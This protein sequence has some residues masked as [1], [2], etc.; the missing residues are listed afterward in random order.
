MAILEDPAPDTTLQR[1]DSVRRAA[2][3]T[4][5][6][7]RGAPAAARA[8]PVRSRP[9]PT[10]MRLA[11]GLV[12]L[13]TASAIVSAMLAPAPSSP[14]TTTA[15]AAAAPPPAPEVIH[16]VRYVQLKPGQTAPPQAVVQHPAAPAPRLVTVTTRQSGV[17]P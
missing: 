4:P 16:V 14:A 9:D 2:G 17:K 15:A 13:A 7:S 6:P 10:A 12:G 5:A 8:V 3:D 1:P 11:G